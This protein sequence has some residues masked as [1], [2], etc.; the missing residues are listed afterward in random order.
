MSDAL[1]AP[2]TLAEAAETAGVA[3]STACAPE[4]AVRV[5]RKVLVRLQA[6]GAPEGVSVVV[7]WEV[8][9]PEARILVTDPEAAEASEPAPLRTSRKRKG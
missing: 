2:R 7:A 9:S 4:D 3:L 6:H 8:G 5:A 1:P